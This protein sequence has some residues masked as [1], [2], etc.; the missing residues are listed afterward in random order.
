ML[1]LAL[2][3]FKKRLSSHNSNLEAIMVKDKSR[4]VRLVIID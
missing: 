2:F 4:A 1:F 3:A